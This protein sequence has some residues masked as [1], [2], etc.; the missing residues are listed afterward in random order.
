MT[1][2]TSGVYVAPPSPCAGQGDNDNDGVC[3]NQDCQPDNPAF[4][5]APGSPCSDGNPNTVNDKVTADGCGCAGTPVSVC[6]NIT[7]GGTIGFGTDCNSAIQYCPTSGPAP[8]IGN[9]ISPT[10]G[11]G[12]LEVVWLKSTTSCT[13]PTTTAAQI[14]AGLD[15]HWS[16]IPGASGLTFSPGVVTQQT[17]YLRCSRRVGCSTFIESNI[18]SLGIDPNCSGSNTPNCNN[19][20]ITTGNGSITVSGLSGAPVAAVLILNATTWA[21]AHSCY[22]GC[23][24]PTATFPVPA[25]SYFVKV[26]YYSAA[27]STLICEKIQTVNVVSAL[28]GYQPEGLQFEAT[29]AEELTSFYWN[30]SS[31]Y[32]VEK[33]V[34]ERSTDG[35]E[36]KQISEQISKGGQSKEIYEDFDLEPATGDNYY[37]L[38]LVNADGSFSY[39]EAQKVNFAKVLDYTIFPNPANSFVKLNLEKI[40]GS[41]N[42]TITIFNNIGLEI[43]RFELD[44]VWSKNYQMDI[45]DLHEGYY[46][47]WLNVPGKRPIAK[48]LMVGRI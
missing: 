23:A 6:D 48:Q 27:P 38:K 12:A 4:P 5:A 17:C 25:G 32:L 2:G 30:H 20:G 19:I 13:F 29:K 8:T 35:I 47:V 24:V 7:L 41:E 1:S 36:F 16:M 15:P 31:G 10:G 18:I 33:Y 11:S 46:V 40:I 44:E 34:V 45:R 37:R 3:N 22:G 28:E 42:V 43:K 39:S 14:A 26:Q 9:C 21:Q